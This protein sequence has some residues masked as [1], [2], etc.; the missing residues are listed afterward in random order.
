MQFVILLSVGKMATSDELQRHLSGSDLGILLTELWSIQPRSI[1]IFGVQLKISYSTIQELEMRINAN[2]VD[3]LRIMLHEA[4]NRDPPLTRR[5]IVTALRNPSVGEERLANQ[6]ESKYSLPQA[7]SS[8][9]NFN[10]AMSAPQSTAPMPM[11]HYPQLP[12]PSVQPMFPRHTSV[13]QHSGGTQS[14]Q[15]PVNIPA[16]E[17]PPSRLLQQPCTDWVGQSNHPPYPIGHNTYQQPLMRNTI[18][19]VMQQALRL[20]QPFQD[21]YFPRPQHGPFISTMYPTVP[22]VSPGYHYPQHAPTLQHSMGA[23]S[24]QPSVQ[25]HLLQQNQAQSFGIPYSHSRH[26]QGSHLDQTDSSHAQSQ[27]MPFSVSTLRSTD[28][29][30]PY[31]SPGHQQLSVVAENVDS[32]PLASVQS[33]QVSQELPSPRQSSANVA[34]ASELPQSLAPSHQL[35]VTALTCLDPSPRS[36]SSSQQAMAAS[37]TS[38]T[39][40]PSTSSSTE[41]PPATKRPRQWSSQSQHIQPQLLTIQSIPATG[42]TQDIQHCSQQS[43]L[44]AADP[45]TAD[46]S[47]VEIF[48]QYAKQKYSAKVVEKDIKWSLSPT[49]EYINLA[50][51]DRRCVKSR[52]Y[53]DVT[54]AMIRDGNV[55]TIQEKKGPIEFS[56]IAKGITLPFNVPKSESDSE[57]VDDRRLILVEG[58]PGVGK[59]T[60]AWEFC[61]RWLK[62]KVAK[63]Y[64]L[65]VLLRLRDKGTR[66][67]R[68]L[69]HLIPDLL[70]GMSEAVCRELVASHTFNA[71]IILEG[72]DELPDSQRND[73]SSIFNELI[74]GELLPLATVLV[75]SRPWATKDI[76]KN[77]ECRMY[78][79]IEVL[80]FTKRQITKYINKTVPKDQVSDL[81]SYLE[82]HPQIKSGMYIPLNSAIVVAVYIAS[83]ADHHPMPNTLT[84]L[85]TA[86]VSIS[87]RRHLQGHPE[88]DRKSMQSLPA[89]NISVPCEVHGNFVSLCRLAFDGMVGESDEVRLIFGEPELPPNFD[90]LG[91]MDSVTELYVTGQ[92]SSSHNFLH[93]TFQEFF[94]AVHISTMP[95]EQQL[96]Y[97][98]KSKT[99]GGKNEGRLKVVLRFL[100]GLRNLDCF[101]RET[102]KYIVRSPSTQVGSKYSTP[103]NISVDVDVVNWLF[104]AQSQTAISLVLEE[105]K[106]EFKAKTSQMMSMDYYSLGYCISHS[107]CQW[108]LSLTGRS[109]VLTKENIKLLADGAVESNGVGK[110]VQLGDDMLVNLPRTNITML[111]AKWSTLL[112]LH[113]LSLFTIPKPWPDLSHLLSFS[114]EGYVTDKGCTDLVSYLASTNCLKKFSLKFKVDCNPKSPTSQQ[115][116][117]LLETVYHHHTLE[118]KSVKEAACRVTTDDDVKALSQICSSYLDSMTTDYIKYV[119]ELTVDGTIVLAEILQHKYRSRELK[120]YASKNGLMSLAKALYRNSTIHTLYLYS[121]DID[122]SGAVSLSQTLHHNSTLSELQLGNNRIGDKGAIALSQTLHHN[123]TLSELQLG[124]NRI[125]DKGAIALSESLYQNSTLKF[126]GLSWNGIGDIGAIAL[127]QSLHQNSTLQILNLSQNSIGDE[128]AIA[129]AQSLHQNSTLQ[130]LNLSG[131]SISGEGA[132]S[133][134]RAPKKLG[135]SLLHD[136]L[137][138]SQHIP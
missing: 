122:E 45:T 22:S 49:V 51:I 44:P 134:A 1:L 56:E 26:G 23:F 110:I 4:L 116:L 135:F 101:T 7:P 138:I 71:L 113:E 67:A 34:I 39:C 88:L 112:H 108:V 33:T 15:W 99:D 18:P 63:Q 125:G 42:D 137:D 24:Q 6:I 81:N 47:K 35:F 91:L 85:Y 96:Q 100:A 52:E 41:G 105:C 20:Q 83:K 36:Y 114:I 5:E 46:L 16:Y 53:E 70:P 69:Q 131:N 59:S 87:I 79:H 11:P 115:L 129:L 3:S 106:V 130:I 14:P 68:F 118:E 77:N 80:G 126:I 127:A 19:N 73:S 38:S 121:N 64:D 123:S 31:H 75:T 17:H 27:S 76:R 43:L 103:C 111:F 93:L 97:F 86:V 54:K 89:I 21:W 90:N 37:A 58:A 61:R 133:L 117:E 13:Q 94:A 102:V 82:R 84:E 74:S 72:Y 62:G 104:E 12:P 57:R 136:S 109:A 9:P 119:G 128:G 25:H 55:D 66:N 92:T 48:I 78:Q 50:C 65:L 40:I 8:D 107:Q 95:E 10:G 124:N 32:S 2:K 30:V 132:V 60:F 29:T 98:K 120:L 28:S